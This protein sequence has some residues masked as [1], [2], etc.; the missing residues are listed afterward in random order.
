MRNELEG[1]KEARKII[2]RFHQCLNSPRLVPEQCYRRNH[3]TYP[4]VSYVNHVMGL[5]LS[6]NYTPIPIFLGRAFGELEKARVELVSEQYREVVLSYLG[7][8]AHFVNDY[9][10]L[11][12]DAALKSYIPSELLKRTPHEPPAIVFLPDEF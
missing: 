8:M 11:D 1:A 5:F 4:L 10:E 2:K 3:G 12:A 6:K 7:H 9:C